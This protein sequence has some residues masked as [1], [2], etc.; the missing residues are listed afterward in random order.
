VANSFSKKKAS[1]SQG[2]TRVKNMDK[3][4]LRQID[5]SNELLTQTASVILVD[6]V[7]IC[8]CFCVSV[9]DIRDVCSGAGEV[10]LPALRD[11]FSLGEGCKSCVK[12][13]SDWIDKVF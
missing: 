2:E 13:A 8:E 10:D 1:V 6:D 5:Q 9:R 12:A 7:L 11:R 3:E 4:F